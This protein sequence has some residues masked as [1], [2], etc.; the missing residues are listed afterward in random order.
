MTSTEFVACLAGA[1]KLTSVIN[2]WRQPTLQANLLA[3]MRS[4]PSAPT[5]IVGEALGYR[6]GRNTGIPFSSS[7]VFTEVEHPFLQALAPQLSLSTDDSE[8]TAT[9]VWEYLATRKQIPLFWNAFPFHPHCKHRPHSNRKPTAAEVRRG[10]PYLQQ[11]ANI[12]QPQQIAG[13]GRKSV[14]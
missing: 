2:P 7:Q 3:Y 10:I 9:I 11:L 12:V 5:L 14:V 8:N 6:G 1:P 4:F 13:L